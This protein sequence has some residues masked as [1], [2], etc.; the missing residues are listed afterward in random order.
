MTS[1]VAGLRESKVAPDAASRHSPL[2]KS[3]EPTL[4]PAGCAVPGPAP[5]SGGVEPGEH[6]VL[7]EAQA[8]PRHRR[9]HATRHRMEEGE[10][11][12][13]LSLDLGDEFLRRHDPVL[14]RGAQRVG[15]CRDLVA[16]LAADARSR[17]PLAVR[18]DLVER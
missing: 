1:P 6:L 3:M 5:R 14:A 13:A 9:G 7:E 2:M 17:H 12:L 8:L 10:P 4:P 15:V 18:V 16:A 11:E